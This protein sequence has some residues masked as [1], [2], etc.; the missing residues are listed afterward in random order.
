MAL[1]EAMATA[2][3]GVSTD[4]GGVRDVITSPASGVLVPFG[5]PEALAKS[6]RQVARAVREAL[7]RVD[8]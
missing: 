1:I 4:V 5:A 6:S 2:V 3:P 8:D 7:L